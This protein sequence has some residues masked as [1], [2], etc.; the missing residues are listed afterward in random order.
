MTLPPTETWPYYSPDEIEAVARV[1]ASGKVNYWTGQEG[2]LFEKEFAEHLGVPHAVALANG[3]VAL[4]AALLALGIGS[5]DEVI[6]PPRTF[7]AT[8]S[9]VVLRGARPVFAD[10]DPNSGN[11]TAESVE[12]GLSPRTRAVIIVHL[13]GWPCEMDPILDLARA[14]NLAVI[15]D[16]A[17]SHGSRYRGR[18]TGSLGDIAAFS[19]CQ[20]KIIS[21]GG[22]GGML[23]TS[24]E[25]LWL[26]AWSAKDHGKDWTAV[27]EA[28]AD[29]PGAPPPSF[30]WLH[31][32]FGSNWRM[33]EPQAAIGRLQLR[34]LNKWVERRRRNAQLLA[35]GLGDLAAL[36]VPQP[37]PHTEP[38]YYRFYAYVRPDAL[39]TG[40]DRDRILA[41][42]AARKIP[43][44]VG[45]CSEVYLE[46]A[47]AAAR[48][49][50]P[51]RLPVAR[52]LGETSIAFLTHPT[53]SEETVSRWIEV[54]RTV[55]TMAT[56]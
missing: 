26:A 39:R 52:E 56:R 51:E 2:R 6:V 25:D 53:L 19:F 31:H 23:V 46:K 36:R 42:F 9:A 49:Q 55:L 8:A 41:E 47:F 1:L 18:L 27:Y 17:Q 15:E 11:L 50:P 35:E 37:P 44:L 4:E 54:A 13:G 21:T 33:T 24:S 14:H 30:R 3:T 43:A 12:Q 34:K 16:C 10:V 32:S 5:G 20:D 40:W 45:S 48:L 28:A 22:E 38:S 29:S 7:V